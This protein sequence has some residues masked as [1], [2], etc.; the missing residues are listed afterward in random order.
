MFV[1]YLF[2]ISKTSWTTARK[3]PL[4]TSICAPKQRK[5]SLQAKESKFLLDL[6]FQCISTDHNLKVTFKVLI[7]LLYEF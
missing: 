6:Y 7:S 3:C 4:E 5:Q 1:N 2:N